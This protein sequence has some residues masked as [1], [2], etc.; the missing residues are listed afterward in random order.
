M[1]VCVRA[2]MG[3]L[4]GMEGKTNKDTAERTVFIK[5]NEQYIYTLG[6]LLIFFDICMYMRNQVNKNQCSWCT[7][8]ANDA[9]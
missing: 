9:R 6:L 8:G 7:R 1:C 5:E 4:R 2:C 3:V